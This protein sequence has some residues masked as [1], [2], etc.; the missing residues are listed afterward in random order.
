MAITTVGLSRVTIFRLGPFTVTHQTEN[1]AISFSNG[2][3]T[4]MIQL[5]TVTVTQLTHEHRLRHRP[6]AARQS[7]P[8]AYWCPRHFLPL[9]NQ[10][11]PPEKR[12]LGYRLSLLNHCLQHFEKGLK[13]VPG[14]CHG[15]LLDRRRK[16]VGVDVWYRG[17]IMSL[18]R[19]LG[20][21]INLSAWEISLDNIGRTKRLPHCIPWR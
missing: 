14:N 9:V 17:V 15:P 5:G 20:S 18:R 13:G 10:Q 16:G 6:V 3:L 7:V 4:C 1:A 21:A 2:C 12:P 19:L 11:I 8:P